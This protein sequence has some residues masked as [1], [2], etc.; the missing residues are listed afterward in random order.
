MSSDNTPADA[1]PTTDAARLR[2]FWRAP[3]RADGQSYTS[4]LA[5]LARLNRRP[6]VR[7]MRALV[8]LCDAL[9]RLTRVVLKTDGDALTADMRAD[10]IRLVKAVRASAL[11]S[12]LPPREADYLGLVA[13]AEA[14]ATDAPR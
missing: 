11:A 13:A 10:L 7:R 2:A 3:R 8:R 1:A 12:D 6:H 9:E 4:G 14:R 5:G